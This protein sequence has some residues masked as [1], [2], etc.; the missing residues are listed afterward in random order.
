MLPT[1]LYLDLA[2]WPRREAHAYF[3]DF[4]KPFFNVCT[5]VDVTRLKA[6]AKRAAG[7]SFSLACHR[8]AL[9]LA[10]DIESFRYRIEDTPGDGR[11]GSSAEPRVRIHPSLRAGLTVLRDDDSFGFAYLEPHA[12]YADFAAQGAA[13]LAA[14]RNPQ[15]L[16]DPRL[17][18]V[19]VIHF[20][21]LPWIHF[22]S[23]SHAR[24]WRREG[25][26]TDSIPKIAFGR[27][28]AEVTAE[29]SANRSGQRLWMPLSVEVHHALMDGLHVGRYV[30]AFEAAMQTPEPFLDL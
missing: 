17:D 13:A 10:N 2:T 15:A 8:I 29:S 21:T 18:D 5:R 19:A 30:Q 28:D 20:T 23:F 25:R 4:D 16:F 7:G 24:N 14:A 12:R 22:T 9:Q 6:A 27:V 26:A 3:R 1:P 11:P